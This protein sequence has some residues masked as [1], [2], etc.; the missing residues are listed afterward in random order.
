MFDSLPTFGAI[1]RR[2]ETSRDIMRHHL[3]LVLVSHIMVTLYT[4]SVLAGISTCGYLVRSSCSTPKSLLQAYQDGVVDINQFVC[5]LTFFR[6]ISSPRSHPF[7]RQQERGIPSCALIHAVSRRRSPP[8][9]SRPFQHQGIPSCALIH[10]VSRRRSPPPRSRPFQHQGIPS[11]ALIHAVSTPARGD[12]PSSPSFASILTPEEGDPPSPCPSC[13]FRHRKKGIP[14]L[15]C[16]SRP[17][18]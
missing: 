16:L 3:L 13:P 2:H 6:K 11:C 17:R 15:P 14:L 8:P 18:T 5:D 4:R 9:R 12:F 7:R 10:A 1:T